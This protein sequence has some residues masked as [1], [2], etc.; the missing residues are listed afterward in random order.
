MCPIWD[1]MHRLVWDLWDP[2]LDTALFKGITATRIG[3]DCTELMFILTECS[4]PAKR[5]ANLSTAPYCSSCWNSFDDGSEG[6]GG[7]LCDGDSSDPFDDE[8]SQ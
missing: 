6:N 1:F 5:S 2:R 3:I 7:L 4:C 8:R